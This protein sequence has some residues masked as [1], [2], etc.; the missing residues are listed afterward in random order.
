[1]I[2]SI[3]STA[4]VLGFLFTLSIAYYLSYWS[5]FDVDVFQYM[6]IEDIIKGVAYPLRY[7]G[8]VILLFT[9]YM[10]F[11]VAIIEFTDEDIGKGISKS[12]FWIFGG[13]AI[14]SLIIYLLAYYNKI[15]VNLA[16]VGFFLSFTVAALFLAIYSVADSIHKKRQ[17]K[18]EEAGNVYTDE[19]IMSDFFN[20]ISALSAAFLFVSAITLG[21]SDAKNIVENKNFDYIMIQNFPKDKI[22]TKQP[23]LVL[24]GVVSEKYIL[25]DCAHNEHFIIDKDDMHVMQTCHFDSEDSL[26]VKRFQRELFK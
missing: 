16:L 2:S 10:L 24:L 18:A 26:S 9:A 11:A 17:K 15:T 19:P 8:F 13:S 12:Q 25:T 3:K 22:H 5:H 6:A 7:A 21:H 20:V 23:Y 1:M 4:V 14:V